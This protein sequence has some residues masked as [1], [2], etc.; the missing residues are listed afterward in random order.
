M[1]DDFS[2]ALEQEGQG[3]TLA[4]F[5]EW[6]PLSQIEQRTLEKHV[7]DSWMNA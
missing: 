2:E 4:D 5:S 3:R 6:K 7:S 1:A